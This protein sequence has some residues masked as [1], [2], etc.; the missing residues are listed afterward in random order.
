M[1]VLIV[2]DSLK[3]IEEARTILSRL[4]HETAANIGP[5]GA[6]FAA[7]VSRPDV[8]FLDLNMPELDGKWLLREI[9]QTGA[10]VF[11]CS[12]AEPGTLRRLARF[13]GADGAITKTEV[14]AASS[15][16]R[17]ILERKS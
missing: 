16:L 6:A 17:A 13:V 7:R 8:V 14:R 10:K 11:F 1:R 5:R 2:D 4:G 12:D 9:K 15:E 3:W